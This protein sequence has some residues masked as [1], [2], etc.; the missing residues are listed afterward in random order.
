MSSPSSVW[1]VLGS[2]PEL[3]EPLWG[4]NS[5]RS[6]LIAAYCVVVFVTSCY[7]TASL[8]VASDAMLSMS[9]L[10]ESMNSSAGMAPGDGT[11]ARLL[12]AAGC[13][14]SP[15]CK[16]LC[17]FAAALAKPKE[18]AEVLE[19]RM[20]RSSASCASWKWDFHFPQLRSSRGNPSNLSFLLGNLFS[21]RRERDTMATSH[22]SYMARPDRLAFRCES[23]QRVM[24]SG[25]LGSLTHQDNIPCWSPMTSITSPPVLVAMRRPRISRR[26]TCLKRVVSFLRKTTHV[27]STWERTNFFPTRLAVRMDDCRSSLRDQ[28]F[29]LRTRTALF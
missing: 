17:I 16:I 21:E 27:S 25:T 18:S 3:L 11:W 19:F 12:D 4:F 22:A 9:T 8:L 5:C 28:F 2:R 24:N 6:A 13:T 26:L 23:S 29:S 20:M 15:L 7:T 10:K 14:V 1:L